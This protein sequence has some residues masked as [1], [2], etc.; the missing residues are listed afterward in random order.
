MPPA[1]GVSRSE[2]IQVRQTLRQTNTQ[3]YALISMWISSW[4]LDSAFIWIRCSSKVREANVQFFK[5]I[6]GEKFC[7]HPK[8]QCDCGE[9]EARFW[10][11]LR[12]QQRNGN[13]NKH[14]YMSLD[15]MFAFWT[16]S[17]EHVVLNF[18]RNHLTRMPWWSLSMDERNARSDPQS[19]SADTF[20]VEYR[21]WRTL[22]ISRG[23]GHFIPVNKVHCKSNLLQMHRSHVAT[24][25][26]ASQPD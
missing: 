3:K 13:G 17:R 26:P 18:N 2:L 14:E 4:F 6:F 12:A 5:W 25:S 9:Y 24:L 21:N 16:Q 19:V 1:C 10:R 23:R 11:F 15:K 22:F 8:C 7:R 20:I